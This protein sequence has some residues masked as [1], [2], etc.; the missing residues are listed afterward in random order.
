MAI[1]PELLNQAC[2]LLNK[3]IEGL[4][5]VY[6]FGSQLNNLSNQESDVDLAILASHKLI[7]LDRHS[8]EQECAQLL[9][10]NVDLIDLLNTD[11]VLAYQIVLEGKV[12]FLKKKL[13]C[14]LFENRIMSQYCNLNEERKEIL[15]DIKKRG[16]VYA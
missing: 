5:A 7:H 15:Q 9:G 12:I 11:T 8:R 1:K 4:I 13:E 6:L 16:R 2:E 14:D 3:K 10:K